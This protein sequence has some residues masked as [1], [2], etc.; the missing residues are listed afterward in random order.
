MQKDILRGIIKVIGLET[1]AQELEI[2]LEIVHVTT[3]HSPQRILCDDVDLVR[4]ILRVTQI[5]C[6]DVFILSRWCFEGTS[7]SQRFISAEAPL[8][9]SHPHILLT[10]WPIALIQYHGLSPS[11]P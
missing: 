7:R 9:I 1:S 5:I 10:D 11:P 4:L 2:R 6:R 8:V 3:P